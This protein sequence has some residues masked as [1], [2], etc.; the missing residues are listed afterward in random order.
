[1]KLLSAFYQH[2]RMHRISVCVPTY[3]RPDTLRQLINSFLRQVY[4]NKELVISDDTPNDTIKNLVKSFN[5][6][7]IKYFHNKTS[8]R[9]AKNFEACM[10]RAT[11]D[12]LITLGDDDVLLNPEVLTNYVHIFKTNPQVAFVYSNQVQ[13]S[14]AMKI[15]YII[16]FVLTDTY[17]NKGEEAMKD[18]W[19]RS[20]FIGGIGIRN[21]PEIVKLYPKRKTLYP[22][23]E[24]IGHIVNRYDTY[25]LAQNNIGFRSHDDQIIFKALKDKTIRQSGEHTTVEFFQIFNK[26]QKQYKL[27]INSDF[28]AQELINLQFV[29]MFKEKAHLGREG[30]TF[31]YNQFRELSQVVR[32][33]KKLQLGYYLAMALPNRVITNARKT[34]FQAF[35]LIKRKEFEKYKK[36]LHEMTSEI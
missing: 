13:F 5:N 28:L 10:Q 2:T 27:H 9:F 17:V 18:V 32:D 34:A 26:L 33:S 6:K 16:N 15:E 3:N 11:G 19:M 20:L 23:V 4:K 21:K 1:M 31:N 22:Q 25:L 7:S 14:D 30:L 24:F 35:K 8:L 36:E 12:Y 29:V